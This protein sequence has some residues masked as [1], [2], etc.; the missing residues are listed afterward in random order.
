MF[1]F[2][3]S[4]FDFSFSSRKGS[5]S[6]VSAADPFGCSFTSIFKGVTERSRTTFVFVS[7]PKMLSVFSVLTSSS[8]GAQEAAFARSVK[9]FSFFV[10]NFLMDSDS[11]SLDRQASQM[12]CGILLSL[13]S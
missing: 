10:H 4:D 7:V 9:N 3:I 12:H 2:L 8:A 1:G 13:L 11:K 5:Q 6:K